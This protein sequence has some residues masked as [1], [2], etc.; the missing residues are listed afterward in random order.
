M[1]LEVALLL[2]LLLA[3]AAQL[4]LLPVLLALLL[5]LL[6]MGWQLLPLLLPTVL[7]TTRS[8]CCELLRVTAE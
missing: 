1:G 6:R 3:V 5:L 8:A 2:L 4:L 7:Q